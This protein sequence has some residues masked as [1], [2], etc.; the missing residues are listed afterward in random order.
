M[1]E[2]EFE[3]AVLKALLRRLQDQSL[4]IRHRGEKVIRVMGMIVEVQGK[5]STD[6]LQTQ[7]AMRM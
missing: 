5:I 1:N 6:A 3:L 7:N 2:R 4:P